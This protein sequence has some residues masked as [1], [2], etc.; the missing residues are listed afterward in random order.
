MDKLIIDREKVKSGFARYTCNY[1]TSDDKIKLKIE[2]TYRVADLCDNIAVNLKMTDYDVELAWGI[3]MLH[4]IGRFEQVRNYGTF[5][6]KD[7][8][9]H[10][11]Y[12]VELLFDRGKI[13]DYIGNTETRD[14]QSLKSNKDY[15]GLQHDTRQ[16]FDSGIPGEDV[17]II[18]ERDNNVADLEI[19]KKAIWN[20]SAYRIEEGLDKRTR[21]FCDIIRDADKI[22]IF[23]VMDDTSAEVIYNV[24]REDIINAEIS[25]GVMQAIR[26]HHAVLRNLK[27]TSVDNIAGHIALAFELVFPVS[28]RIARK[29]G[30][31]DK[32]MDFRTVNRKTK[33]QLSEIRSIIEEYFDKT[34]QPA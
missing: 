8:I 4:D 15:Y 23:K 26:E 27:K 34:C 5:S 17:N 22:D 19:I 20:H 21:L 29:Q 12:A 24:S 32:L 33:E 7:S 10:A 25:E 3:G 14:L 1:D 9:D 31:L 13:K 6:D 16:T 11:H 18:G 2:H 30:Y 28:I